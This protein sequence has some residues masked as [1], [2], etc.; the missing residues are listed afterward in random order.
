MGLIKSNWMA[1]LRIRRRQ[2]ESATDGFTLWK[3]VPYEDTK[4]V[5]CGHKE[6]VSTKPIRFFFV[7][8]IVHEWND[9]YKQFVQLGTHQIQVINETTWPSRLRFYTMQEHQLT[10]I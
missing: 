6:I 10:D 2:R 7:V 3:W 9:I 1:I 5:R 4:H 8:F